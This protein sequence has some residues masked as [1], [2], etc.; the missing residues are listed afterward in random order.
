MARVLK[1][2]TITVTRSAKKVIR[3][4]ESIAGVNVPKA[5]TVLALSARSQRVSVVDGAILSNVTIARNGAYSGMRIARLAITARDVAC[6]LRTAPKEWPKSLEV[7]VALRP[8]ILDRTWR[9]Q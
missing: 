7:T 1:K 6:V 8:S 5:L 4:L 3:V 9:S 2:L